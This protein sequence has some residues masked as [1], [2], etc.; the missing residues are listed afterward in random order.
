MITR[1]PLAV[2]RIAVPAFLAVLSLAGTASAEM[3]PAPM[4]SLL[5]VAVTDDGVAAPAPAAATTLIDS[6]QAG[7]AFRS[8]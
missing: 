4:A 8:F 5:L 6:Q 1:A 2:L 7:R 3:P